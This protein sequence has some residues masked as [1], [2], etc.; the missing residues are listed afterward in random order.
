M[1]E[2]L[3]KDQQFRNLGANFGQNELSE[4]AVSIKCSYLSSVESKII[5]DHILSER[6]PRQYDI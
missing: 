6:F 4:T 1:E 3:C 5:V 2:T